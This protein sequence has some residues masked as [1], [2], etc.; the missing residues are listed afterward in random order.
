[1]ANKKY[2]P[3]ALTR[4]LLVLLFVAP[5]AYMGASYYHGEDG[6]ENIKSLFGIEQNDAHRTKGTN[7]NRNLEEENSILIKQND[8]LNQENKALKEEL[9]ALKKK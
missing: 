1:M 6:I 9:E 8:A 7:T 2:K 3:T 4:L 5:I